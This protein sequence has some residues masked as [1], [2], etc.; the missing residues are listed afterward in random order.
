M[1]ISEIRDSVIIP[2][3]EFAGVPVIEQDDIGDQPTGP[4]AT[5]KFTSAYIKDVGMGEEWAEET[6]STYTLNR[7]EMFKVTLSFNAYDMD[8]DESYDLATKLN[9]WFR[10]YGQE[11]LESAGIAVVSV[12]NIENR[13]SFVV[14]EYE[15]RN[16]FDVI[17]RVGK[18]MALDVGYIEKVEINDK[19][20]P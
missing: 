9:E 14:D 20:Y 15:R 8:S 13:D 10:F 12:G 6:Q 19:L 1:K 4:H 3:H 18:E 17:L 7:R 11:L 2:L 5:Y 16:G